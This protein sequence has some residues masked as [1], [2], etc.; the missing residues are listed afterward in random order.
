MA[1]E[2][3]QF[4]LD[5]QDFYEARVIFQLRIEEPPSISIIGS[6]KVKNN[7][8]PNPTTPSSSSVPSVTNDTTENLLGG[9][10]VVTQQRTKVTLGQRVSL[11]LPKGVQIQDGVLYERADLGRIGAGAE[12]GVQNG[13][14]L[15]R[16]YAQSIQ[17]AASSLTE[18]FDKT[19]S[20]DAARLAA[21]RAA[22]VGGQKF[23]DG[24]QSALRVAT[25]PN[26]R[27]LFKEVNIRE[28]TF[29]F[30]FI[31]T[32]Q[33]EAEMAKRIIKFFRT[34][35][36]P[37]NSIKIDVGAGKNIPVGYRFPNTFDIK[38][39][40]RDTNIIH[41]LLPC[42]LTNISTN[43]NPTGPGFFEDG[44]F[45]EIEM[46]MTFRESRTLSKELVRDE[47]Y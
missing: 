30:K 8:V 22:R 6:K 2:K 32:S 28:F 15:S 41:R 14:Q 43:Y 16:V 13:D 31:P 5:D 34:E 46:S 42:Y 37:E 21:T 20:P 27:Q 35:L 26:Q 24:V 4:P 7:N 44:N 23:G 45:T 9:R 18:L 36:Y 12:L 40:H 47:G 19:L 33:P 29:S 17:D 38:F 39:K 3:L 1:T 25:N 11:Y 10:Q